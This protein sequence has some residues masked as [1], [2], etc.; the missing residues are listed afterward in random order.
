MHSSSQI[1][2][3]VLGL[4]LELLL[5][6]HHI[7]DQLKS[8]DSD[9]SLKGVAQSVKPP[10]VLRA[11]PLVAASLLNLLALAIPGQLEGIVCAVLRPRDHG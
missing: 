3:G 5:R 10:W 11:W 1:P 9:F 8:S 6:S 7:V 2:V 4:G